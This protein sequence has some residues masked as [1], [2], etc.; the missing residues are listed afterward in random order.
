MSFPWHNQSWRETAEFL[1]L[2][3]RP[4]ERILAPDAYW[5]IVS[6]VERYVPANLTT[7]RVYDWVVLD[8]DDMPQV[9]RAFLEHVDTTMTPVF[10]NEQ[11]V[12]WSAD[13]A[14][15]PAP[16]LGTHIA[17]FPPLLAQQGAEPC[18]PNRYVEDAAL[19]D[20]PNLMRFADLS[21]PELRAEM[22]RFFER[23][24]YLYPTHRDQ[25]YRQDV[26]A[27]V[28]SFMEQCRG[29]VL[30]VCAGGLAFVDVPDGMQI[31]R[32]DLS[33]VGVRRARVADSAAPSITHAVMDAQRM[34]FPD[35]AFDDVLFVD[36]IE[37]VRDAA[38]VLREA[39]R[40]LVS[41]GRL[42][43]TFANRKSVHEVLARKLGHPPFETNQQHIR[44]FSFAE[45]RGVLKDMEFEIERTEG[46]SLYPYWGVPGVDEVVRTVIDDDPEFVDLM[47]ELGRLVGAEHAYTGVVFARRRP[48]A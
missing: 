24:G 14:C 45:V 11:F 18:E 30:E 34:A 12:V 21:D 37:D 29:R 33:E 23:T 4:G 20:A 1:S 36:A 32:T 26:L 35:A 47:H 16:A 43:V 8:G 40:V 42:M 19:G 28:A 10:A 41:G 17:W 39:A 25:V 31:V 46:I 27:Q 2:H 6:R 44:E 13:A 3:T 38:A 9:P 15:P 7:E 48:R 5:W 22:N